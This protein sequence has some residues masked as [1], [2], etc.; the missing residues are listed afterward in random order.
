MS[1]AQNEEPLPQIQ[2]DNLGAEPS[3]K[4]TFRMSI[5]K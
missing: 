4:A 1:I 5:N 3:V 2:K